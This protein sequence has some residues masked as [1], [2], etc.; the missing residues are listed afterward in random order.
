VGMAMLAMCALVG[1]I[2]PASARSPGPIVVDESFRAYDQPL[3]GPAKLH[4]VELSVLDDAD[5]T[6]LVDA[7]V[8]VHN[9][10]DLGS[11]V[12]RTDPRGRVRFVY[13]S[14]HDEAAARV[15]VRKAGYVPL[16][17]AWGT[18]DGPWAPRVLPLRLRRGVTMGGIVVDES[19]RPVS[20]AT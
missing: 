11:H 17:Y 2:R 19:G 3:P 15:E 18:D 4:T 9:Q 6:P 13:P 20:G 5:G 7:D 8:T 10:L 1:S 16:G 12:R 14:L